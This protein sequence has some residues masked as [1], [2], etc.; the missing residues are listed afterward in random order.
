M[1]RDV[2]G[3]IELMRG[4]VPDFSVDEISLDDLSLAVAWG[5]VPVRGTTVEF[6]TAEPVGPAFMR[7]VG[8]VHRELYAEHAELY[9]ENIRGKIERCLAIGDAEYDA[10]VR[11]RAEHAERAFAAVDGFD[12]LVT[13]TL[14]IDPPPAD[15]VEV[16]IRSELTLFTFPFNALG[17]PVLALP[18]GRGSAQ[19]IGRPGDDALVLAAGLELERRLTSA[20]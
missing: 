17:W 4:L 11:A 7:E 18:A 10:A 13:P 16:E 12:L 2:A 1:A 15:V 9:G 3:C 19:V 14:S 6:P 20:P 5:D 8:D